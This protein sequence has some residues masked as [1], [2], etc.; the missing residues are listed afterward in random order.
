MWATPA[1][2]VTLGASPQVV[3]NS[4]P[5]KLESWAGRASSL[6]WVPA[7]KKTLPQV[8]VVSVAVKTQSIPPAGR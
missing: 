6:T 1:A 7:G 8:P 5:K 3:S 4:Q 2:T